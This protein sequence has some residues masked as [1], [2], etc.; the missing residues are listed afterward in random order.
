MPAK[1][2]PLWLDEDRWRTAQDPASPAPPG[3]MVLR[4]HRA[5]SYSHP[6]AARRNGGATKL[7]KAATNAAL[8]VLDF[9]LPVISHVVI[10]NLFIYFTG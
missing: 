4:P 8:A 9:S 5:Q 10:Y 6:Q 2:D 7:S 1:H 3:G